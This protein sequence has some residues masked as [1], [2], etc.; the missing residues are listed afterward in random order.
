M[1]AIPESLVGDDSMIVAGRE[2]FFLGYPGG[3]AG[4]NSQVPLV[5]GALI[6]GDF[7]HKIIL[8][9]NIF[10]GSS[11]S[12]LFLNPDLENDVL[13]QRLI[14]I[15]SE[16]RAIPTKTDTSVVENMGIGIAIKISYIITTI[17]NW[18]NEQQ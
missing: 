14:G 2:V 3:L 11:G 4:Y 15:V 8:D 17:E 12:P 5:R 18:L 6:A 7:R 10:G 13:S 16:M 9:G 1:A